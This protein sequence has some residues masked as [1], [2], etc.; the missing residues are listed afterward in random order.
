[1]VGEEMVEPLWKWGNQ[2]DSWC[3]GVE[4]TVEMAEGDLESLSLEVFNNRGG[5]CHCCLG[6]GSA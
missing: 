2:E 3:A 5:S 6:C 4:Q 1:M